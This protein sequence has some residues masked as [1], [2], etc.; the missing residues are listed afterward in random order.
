MSTVTHQTALKVIYWNAAAA[1]LLICL[2]GASV[3]RTHHRYDNLNA[4][5]I[6]NIPRLAR[7]EGFFS[8]R[9][10]EQYDVDDNT[11]PIGVWW[12]EDELT[13]L[14]QEAGWNSRIKYMDK[15]FYAA[16]YRFD[17]ILSR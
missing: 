11:S 13:E 6:G 10:I 8:N 17:L 7:A 9:N 3:I 2:A 1:V 14:A 16:A 5:Y 15:D 4:V 12:D